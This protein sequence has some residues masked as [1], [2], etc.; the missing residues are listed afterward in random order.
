MIFADRV[1]KTNYLFN[2]MK[3][4]III[5]DDDEEILQICSLILRS[6][7][8]H[9]V[10]ETHCEDVIGKILTAN[11]QV[12]MMD[13]FIPDIGGVAA[14]RLIKKNPATSHIPVIFFSGHFDMDSLTAEAGADYS[15]PKPF[16]IA[17]LEQIILTAL[18]PGLPKF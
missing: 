8:Y 1:A 14:I 12:V 6:K 3:N 13:N 2:P 16:D 11:A 15:L 17:K 18:Q 7:G 5:F 9:V 10:T 4:T